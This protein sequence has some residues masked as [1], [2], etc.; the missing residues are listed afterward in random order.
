MPHA[1]VSVG[2]LIGWISLNRLL[3]RRSVPEWQMYEFEF[4]SKFSVLLLFVKSLAVTL[5]LECLKLTGHSAML[6]HQQL[7]FTDTVS[8]FWHN[9]AQAPCQFTMFTVTY[10]LSSMCAALAL[11][12]VFC[13]CMCVGGVLW[14]PGAWVFYLFLLLLSSNNA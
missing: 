14:P 3:V 5:M 6:L 11:V 4:Y 2:R 12:G 8:I 9:H 10:M 7:I 13:V 1:Q